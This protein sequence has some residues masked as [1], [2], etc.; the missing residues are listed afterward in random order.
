MP[1]NTYEPWHGI[2]NNVE[3][4]TSKASDQACAYAQS[5]QS[6]CWSLEYSMSF[7]LLNEHNLEFLS[8]TGDCPGSSEST[9]VE[10]PHCWKS[11]ATAQLFIVVSTL[12]AKSHLTLTFDTS[13]PNELRSMGGSRGGGGGTGS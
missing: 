3:C 12:Y 13:L 8:L 9:L 4:A 7:K 5:D 10:M 2:S 1:M 6:L 11:H